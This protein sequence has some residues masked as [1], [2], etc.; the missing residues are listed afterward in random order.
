MRRFILIGLAIWC[1]CASAKDMLPVRDGSGVC[2]SGGDGFCYEWKMSI[3][4]S[5]HFVG[6][7]FEDGA[8]YFFYRVNKGKHTPLLRIYPVI[9]DARYPKQMFWGYPWDIK[10]ITSQSGNEVVLHAAITLSK[11]F[12]DSADQDV[13][14]TTPTGQHRIPAVLFVGKTTQREMVVDPLSYKTIKLSDL[15]K[16]AAQ[17]K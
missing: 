1:G 11:K 4:P 13:E 2:K 15:I 14:D 5:I 6:I 9:K 8:S 3:D 7:G 12:E 16:Q 17:K 10:D